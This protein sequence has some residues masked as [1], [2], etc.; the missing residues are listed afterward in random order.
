MF[1]INELKK[2]K[3]M[4]YIL[5]ISLMLLVSCSDKPKVVYVDSI[6]VQTVEKPVIQ[7]VPSEVCFNNVVYYNTGY[8]NHNYTPKVVLI[9]GQNNVKI[10][11][12]VSC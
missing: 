12:G 1:S 9:N 2:A 5:L 3:Q 7:A 10:M 8:R 4:K 11:S 6:T